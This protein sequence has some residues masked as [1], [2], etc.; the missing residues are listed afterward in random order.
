MRVIA[1]FDSLLES[2]AGLQSIVRTAAALA[3]C[4]VRLADPARRLTVRVLG[5]GAAAGFDGEPDSAWPSAAV[6]GDGATLWLEM[7]GPAGTV[8]AVVLERAAGAARTVI[9]R[10]RG[11]R[12][13]ED[14]ASLELLLDASATPADRL[15]AA[16]RLGLPSRVRAL[17]LADGT[18]RVVP[19]EPSEPITGRAGVG[20]AVAPVDAPISWEAAALALRLTAAGTTVDPGPS[21]VHA[22]DLGTLPLLIRAADSEPAPIP[23]VRVL[24]RA[25]TA[26]PWMLPTLDAVA[27]ASSLRD[28]ARA[29]RVHHST[30]QDR[31]THA[32]GLLGWDVREQPGRLRLQLALVLRRALRAPR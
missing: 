26:G 25:S 22:D 32:A 6:T 5:D 1:H 3:G 16:A 19:A 28:A 23:D 4:P 14:P 27:S 11:R 17:A 8:E 2:R 10:T 20:P 12:A 9:T 15:A 30:V 24:E 21:V 13:E 7:T 18:V 29:L 31:L